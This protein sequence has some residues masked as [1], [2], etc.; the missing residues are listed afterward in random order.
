MKH[1]IQIMLSEDQAN[2]L[3]DVSVRTGET[4]ASFVRRAVASLMSPQRVSPQRSA[5]LSSQPRQVD[6]QVPACAFPGLKAAD[7]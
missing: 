6:V 1:R 5:A 2:Y 7:G 4:V 3:R